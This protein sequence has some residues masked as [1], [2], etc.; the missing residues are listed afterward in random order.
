MK[1]RRW[2]GVVLLLF[3]STYGGNAA[4]RD[5]A[6]AAS[7]GAGGDADGA[8]LD[9]ATAL[10]RDPARWGVEDVQRWLHLRGYGEYAPAF[11][12]QRVTGERLVTV[13]DERLRE[14]FGVRKLGTRKRLV[15]AIIELGRAVDFYGAPRGR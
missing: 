5:D 9:A 8:A 1:P 2:R 13:R 7:L 10:A 4:D 6:V 14:M 11:R 15:A 3:A 12:A